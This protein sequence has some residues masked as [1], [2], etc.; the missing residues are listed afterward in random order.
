MPKVSKANSLRCNTQG[1]HFRAIKSKTCDAVA[2][3][4]GDQMPLDL[5]A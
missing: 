1:N 5:F 2:A 3:E 4:E